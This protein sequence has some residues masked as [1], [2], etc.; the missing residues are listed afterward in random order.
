MPRDV[1]FEMPADTSMFTPLQLQPRKLLS[2]GMSGWARWC[3][4]HLVPFPALVREHST[5]LVVTGLEIEYLDPLGFF[6][7]DLIEFRVTVRARSGGT[8]LQ[9]SMDCGAGAQTAVH[10]KALCVPVLIQDAQSLSAIPGRLPGPLLARF[11]ADEMISQP[12]PRRLRKELRA[13]AHG[14]PACEEK[15]SFTVHRDLCEVADQWSY[16]ELP[17]MVAPGRE[18]IS[19]NPPPGLDALRAGVSRPL[20][21]LD[22]EIRRPFY[23]FDSGMVVSKAYLL[24]SRI[25]FVHELWNGT[26]DDHPHAT[27]IEQFGTAG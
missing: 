23:A 12:S 14:S 16:I 10:M 5:S 3:R 25:A 9:M 4:E 26:N 27:V 20:I 7:A 13:I 17:G 21:R 15:T 2:I 18:A 11:Q 8:S 6:D 24:P 22:A 1:T 19:L